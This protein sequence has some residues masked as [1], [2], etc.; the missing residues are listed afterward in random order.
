MTRK[1]SGTWSS[2]SDSVM[3]AAAEYFYRAMKISLIVINHT[4][5]VNFIYDLNN[6]KYSYVCVVLPQ[7]PSIRI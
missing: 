4:C 2:D 3:S 1:A 6:K 7:K 5:Q